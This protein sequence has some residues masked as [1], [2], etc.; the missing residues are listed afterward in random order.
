[1]TVVDGKTT[2]SEFFGTVFSLKHSQ[3]SQGIYQVIELSLE[4]EGI[5]TIRAIEH[6]TNPDL[7]SLVALDLINQTDF[8]EDYS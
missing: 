2:D 5:V 7:V 1:M 8:V 3:T 6:P 4:E